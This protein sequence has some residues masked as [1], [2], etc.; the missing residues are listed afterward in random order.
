MISHVESLHFGGVRE[1]QGS[2]RIKDWGGSYFVEDYDE[3]IR[4]LN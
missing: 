1:D 2:L 4:C 3:V